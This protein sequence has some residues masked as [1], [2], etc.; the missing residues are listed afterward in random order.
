MILN[1]NKIGL[2]VGIFL[3]IV[4]IVWS[5]AVLIIPIQLQTFLNW[6]FV[7]HALQPYWVITAFNFVNAILLAVMTFIMGYIFGWVFAWCHN[8][9][10]K[11]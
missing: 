2:V 10:H 3:A 11:K 4:H 7:L 5:L 1:K 8:L 6:I 9:M